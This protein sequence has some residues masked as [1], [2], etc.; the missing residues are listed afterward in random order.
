[1]KAWSKSCRYIWDAFSV[2]NGSVDPPIR[3]AEIFGQFL[4]GNN[5]SSTRLTNGRQFDFLPDHASSGELRNFAVGEGIREFLFLP[6][7]LICHTPNN[8][9]I[10]KDGVR[11][12]VCYDIIKIQIQVLPPIFHFFLIHIDGRGPFQSW[13]FLLFGK[14]TIS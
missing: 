5:P 12:V 6:A 4:F 3:D 1:M 7:A 2:V 9:K 13:F 11:N 8:S 10:Q 14:N